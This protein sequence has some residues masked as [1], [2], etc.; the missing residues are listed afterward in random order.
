[1]HYS[2]ALLQ[3]SPLADRLRLSESISAGALGVAL[4]LT[5]ATQLRA[6]LLPVGPGEV[7]L[8]FWLVGATLA[9]A[10]RGLV[11]RT[12]LVQPVLL[13]W[14]STLLALCAGWCAGIF[15]NVWDPASTRDA[16]AILLASAVVV[17]SVVQTESFARIWCAAGALSITLVLGLGGLLV[18]VGL[19]RPGFGPIASMYGFR[20][21]GWA[22]NPNQA[23]LAV[24]VVPFLAWEHSRY[25]STKSLRF[26]WRLVAFGA[27]VIG[28]ATL[29]DA[30]TLGWAAAAVCGGG[31]WW[32]KSTFTRTRFRSRKFLAVFGA[33]LLVAAAAV[34][35]GPRLIAYVERAAE[36]SYD[37]GG[38]GSDR[39]A[40]WQH[41]IDAAGKSPVVGLGPGSYSGPFAAFQG[42]EAHNTPIDWMDATGV[43]GLLSL[44][45]FWCWTALRIHASGRVH[46]ALAFCALLVFSMFHFVLRQPVFWFFLLSL[47]APL[48]A[49]LTR[50]RVDVR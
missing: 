24:S 3:G 22:V 39:V 5:S 35:I 32:W 26:C 1:M 47:A 2:L 19:G 45:A 38:Q 27:V 28:V 14:L 34:V 44:L 37:E 7:L 46:A 42:E 21:A 13:F 40:R 43:V 6:P 20:F 25:A 18:L 49:R 50:V 10:R 9:F 41:G 36:T 8:V 31:V 4:G 30:L 11:T 48:P 33:P 15:L 17:L 23:S 16:I 29:S 12:L